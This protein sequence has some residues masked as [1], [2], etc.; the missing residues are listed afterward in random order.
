MIAEN[1]CLPKQFLQVA[2]KVR[3]RH[4]PYAPLPSLIVWKPYIGRD[5][6]L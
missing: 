1:N 4:N 3:G 2:F 5:A 6:R